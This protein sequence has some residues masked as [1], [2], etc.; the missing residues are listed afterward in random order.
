M[1]RENPSYVTSWLVHGLLEAD[2]AVPAGSLPPRPIDVARGMVDWYS[3]QQTNPRLPE[4]LP[5]DR[6]TSNIPSM[7]GN[8]TGHQIYLISQGII[9]HTRMATSVRGRMRDVELVQTLYEEDEWLA[10]LSTK[11]PN[12]IWLKRWFPHN[13]EVTAFEAYLDMYSLTGESKY[14]DAMVGAW[15]MFRENWIHLGGSMAINEGSDGL[16]TSKGLWY[17]PKSYYLEGDP[18]DVGPAGGRHVTGETCGSVFWIKFNQRFHRLNPTSE[19][20]TA[21]IERSLLNIGIANQAPSVGSPQTGI[22]Y[23]ALLHGHKEAMT[24]ISTC[25]EGQ[26]TRLHGSLPEYIFSIPPAGTT[27][28]SVFVNLYVSSSI[29]ILHPTVHTNMTLQISSDFPAI[30]QASKPTTVTVT[31]GASLGVLATLHLRIPRWAGPGSV[32]V[33]LNH[34]ESYALAT[35]GSYLQI[36]RR[37]TSGDSVSVGLRMKLTSTRYIGLNQVNG[38]TRFGFEFGP[39][40]LAAVPSSASLWNSET[41][42]LHLPHDPEQPVEWL[43][44]VVGTPLHFSVRLGAGTVEFMPYY[45]VNDQLMTVFPCFPPVVVA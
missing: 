9:H 11:N 21:E 41:N 31:H 13:Y 30:E 33:G 1:Y 26:G 3:A 27:E 45:E 44:P 35:P 38:S 2:V 28:F 6:T 15:E 40:L 12:G 19:Q 7:F 4:F 29:T 25:C 42:C 16:D 8:T 43:Q 23:F 34:N 18:H 10:Q 39:T 20:Y 22:R 36:E 24:N 37:W 17:P 5:A 14:H 32:V